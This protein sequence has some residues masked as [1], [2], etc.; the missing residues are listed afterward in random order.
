MAVLLCCRIAQRL[1]VMIM[2]ARG[3]RHHGAISRSNS[4]IAILILFYHEHGSEEGERRDLPIDEHRET[5][6]KLRHF[7]EKGEGQLFLCISRFKTFNPYN[8]VSG[9]PCFLDFCGALL[10]HDLQHSYASLL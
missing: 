3:H 5:L 2:I 1:I 8:D 4:L 10:F 9:F 6:N 7:S